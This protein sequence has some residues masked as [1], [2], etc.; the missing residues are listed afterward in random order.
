MHFLLSP[1][2]SLNCDGLILPH[3]EAK[4]IFIKEAD[5]LAKALRR[6]K[7]KE[8]SALM[9]ISDKLGELNYH[10]YQRWNEDMEGEESK[11]AVYMF[12]GDVY[13]G[14]SVEECTPKQVEYI[15]STTLILSG[16]YGL[17]K[18]LDRILPYRL[19]MGT[20]LKT[21][22]GIGLYAYW[23]DKLSK[24]INALGDDAVV[25]LASNE[26]FKSVNKS[27]LKR[28]VIEIKFKEWKNGE[29]KIISFFAKKARGMMVR[30]AAEN[31]VRKLE[32]LKNFDF[33]GYSFEMKVSDDQV[34]EFRRKKT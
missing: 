14:L 28:P 32:D 15:Q 34:W 20:R 27:V 23:G 18:P 5:I 33:E 31:E 26:Y 22:K 9:H 19:E 13:Q 16:L 1:A 25:N 29:Y 17:L 4:P 21:R 12:Q 2:K 6:K 3:N 7:P 10:R 24:A 8:L 11:E 30:W